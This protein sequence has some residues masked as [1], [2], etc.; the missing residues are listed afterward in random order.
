MINQARDRDFLPLSILVDGT[1]LDGRGRGIFFESADAT[2]AASIN[3]MA[4]H[5]FG[6]VSVA[7]AA[8]RAYAL[9]LSPI[10]NSPR[11]PQSPLFLTSVEGGDC[12]E[13]GISAA[14]RAIT[15]TTLGRPDC[16]RDDIV[17]PG[18]IMPAVVAEVLDD[19]SALCEHAYKY[20]ERSAGSHAVTWCDILNETGETASADECRA[21]AKALE[22]PLYVRRDLAVI[23]FRRLSEDQ[24]ALY[25]EVRDGDV[26][27][28][29]FA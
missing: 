28:D 2:S 7:L 14:E 17:T 1:A 19:A 15:A 13:T 6:I 11:R 9:G 12:T 20:A 27:L 5:G 18:H 3:R 22:V 24:Q 29:Q 23:E 16:S 4:R 10:S 8:S 26:S 21:L 25:F